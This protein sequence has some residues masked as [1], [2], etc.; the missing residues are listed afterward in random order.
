MNNPGS[1]CDTLVALP[2]FTKNNSLIFAKNSDREPDEAQAIVHIPRKKYSEKF[3]KCTFIPI[4]QIEET[5]EIVISKPFQM[6]GAEMGANEFGLVIGNEAVFTKVKIRKKNEGLTGMD[7]LRLALERTKNAQESLEMYHRII[8]INMVRM[9]VEVIKTRI[10]STITVS[11]LQ[12]I[13]KLLFWKP[14]GNPGP[15][16]K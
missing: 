16:R 9:P 2:N 15:V 6:W 8:G 5:Y 1:M 14:Q 13:E 4:P 12:I 11:S 10:S 7:L 3:L